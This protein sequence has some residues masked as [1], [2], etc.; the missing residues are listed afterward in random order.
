MTVPTGPGATPR[1]TMS[2]SGPHRALITVCVMAATLMQALDSTIANVALPY[3]QGSLSASADEITWVLTSYITAAAIMTAPVGWFAS[4]F[5]RRN[6][7]L[8]CLV[9]F[10]A[11]SMLCGAAQSLPQMVIFR[12]LQGVFGAALVPMSQSTM[13][14]IYPPEKHGSAMAMWGVGVMLGPILGP[15]VGGYLTDLYT[16]RWVFYVNLPVGILACAGLLAFMP[17]E[18][19]KSEM[20]FDWIGFAALALGIGAFQ[21]MLDRGHNQDWF[22]STEIV[23]EAVLAGLGCYLFVVHM[24]T[25]DKPFMPPELFKDRN[26]TAGLAMMFAVGVVLVATSALLA[27]WL[28]T[29][30]DYPVAMAGLVL[31]P[32]GIGTMA[33]M[34]LGGRLI[35]RVDPRLM[36]GIGLVLLCVSLNMMTGWNPGV[37]QQ[38]IVLAILLQGF[39]LG[40]VF[41]PMQ[42]VTFATLPAHLRNDGTALLSLFRNVGSAV[43]VAVTSAALARNVQVLH[44]QIAESATPFNRAMQAQKLLDP[45]TR[46]GLALLDQ[47]V[48]QQALIIAYIDDYKLMILS[49][50]PALLLL[51]LMRGPRRTGKPPAQDAHALLD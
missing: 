33:S 1:G 43:G 46:H 14:D 41:V 51:F 44:S 40:L 29:L 37:A 17:K 30:A 50:L 48:N 22:S 31:S 25:A 36:I 49:S 28:Q 47:I 2:A 10:T 11:A 9:G 13:L 38:E 23:T 4:R 16:W 26:F 15:T 21:M 34:L 7:F 6:V 42:V 32:R 19:P 20:R 27:P 8:V 12:L 35:A 5:G 24:L 3:M 45:A 39:G 18:A